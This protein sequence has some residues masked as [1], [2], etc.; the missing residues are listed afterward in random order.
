LHFSNI[1]EHEK[2]IMGEID[3]LRRERNVVVHEGKVLGHIEA[4]RAVDAV[5]A[6]FEIISA[7]SIQ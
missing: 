1:D 4:R 3:W 6:L 5:Q 7:R 2:R